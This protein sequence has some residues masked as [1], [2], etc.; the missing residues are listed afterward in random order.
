MAVE[1]FV[2]AVR[3]NKHHMRAARRQLR[4]LLQ[5]ARCFPAAPYH[6]HRKK[7]TTWSAGWAIALALSCIVVLVYRPPQQSPNIAERRVCPAGM[8][9]AL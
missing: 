5:D 1:N 3:G 9:S 8:E 6:V 2:A 4:A 7:M